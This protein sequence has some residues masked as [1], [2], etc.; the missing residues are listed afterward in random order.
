MI[1]EW[2]QVHLMLSHYQWERLTL[3]LDGNQSL[4]GTRIGLRMRV[5]CFCT[6]TVRPAAK[7]PILLALLGKSNADIVPGSGSLAWFGLLI[8]GDSQMRDMVQ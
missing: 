6:Q 5:R 3:I 8:R 4:L 7:T 2:I 1:L